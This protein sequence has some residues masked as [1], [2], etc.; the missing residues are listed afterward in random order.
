MNFFRQKNKFLIQKKK[1]IFLTLCLLVLVVPLFSA[2][3]QVVRDASG[4]VTFINGKTAI[5]YGPGPEGGEIIYETI[6][7]IGGTGNGVTQ[8]FTLDP[9]GNIVHISTGAFPDNTGNIV[10]TSGAGA[11]EDG[12]C[13]FS[14]PINCLAQG[15]YYVLFLINKILL[16]VGLLFDFVIL[17]TLVKMSEMIG[18]IDGIQAGWVAIR[19]LSNII[20]IFA[21]LYISIATILR[22]SGYQAKE[23][24]VKV[25]IVALLINF[26]LFFTKVIIDVANTFSTVFYNQITASNG[27]GGGAGLAD[28]F[29][30]PF[31]LATIASTEK[32]PDPLGGTTAN[33]D[34]AK[35]FASSPNAFTLFMVGSIFMLIAIFVFF[36]ATI[37]FLIR[38]VVL[39]ILMVLSPFAFAGSILPKTKTYADKWWTSLIAESFFAPLFMIMIWLSLKIID[40]NGFATLTGTDGQPGAAKTLA[41][42]II[43]PSSGK[44]ALVMK[45]AI[46]IVFLIASL[47]ISKQLT[48]QASGAALKAYEW[49][50]KKAQR[51]LGAA[52]FG[53]AGLGLRY[54][55]G[56]RSA[57]FL[58]TD[59]GK[60]LES[61]K[62]LVDK[63]RYD[64][65]AGL[66][67]S[68][69]DARALAG[70][71]SGMG[72]AAGTG[73][74]EKITERREKALIEASKRQARASSEELAKIAGAVKEEGD[75]KAEREAI[76]FEDKEKTKPLAVR[77]H[78]IDVKAGKDE[79]ALQAVE[80]R[81]TKHSEASLQAIL[82]KDPEAKS[83]ADEE[84]RKA[85]ADKSRL[86]RSLRNINSERDE[87]RGSI[88][89]LSDT[90]KANVEKFKQVSRVMDKAA[91][92][93]SRVKQDAKDAGDVRKHAYLSEKER[94][95]VY[96]LGVF[97]PKQEINKIRVDMSKSK[98]ERRIDDF[99]EVLDELEK[100]EKKTESGIEHLEE[101]IK[102]VADDVEESKK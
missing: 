13:G 82:N 74:Y 86:E 37:L 7:T 68:S 59:K 95:S 40:G 14:H 76:P 83:L 49:T 90:E 15:A 4:H 47:I 92:K 31:N 30:K 67:K 94:P 41:Q 33:S 88:D 78:E 27:T 54:S 85:A 9:S 99:K 69:F 53:A 89:K 26:S 84:L 71:Q 3:A 46:V 39:V 21:L 81:M 58:Q 29:M 100:G 48:G 45:F 77:S 61:S 51:G 34:Q 10:P 64:A 97:A 20:I 43:D 102:G 52:T 19:D 75:K 91:D 32:N 56:R 36:A 6:G 22:L 1:Y 2:H 60:A 24:L 73:G 11:A 16:L 57:Q 55:L 23:L 28:R 35:V 70:K 50:R 98:K 96:N 101:E 18:K 62:R 38:F 25:I 42:S 65:H 5:E 63:I 72:Q 8:F 93:I 44:P 17:N 12:T 87:L 80:A 79:K 66:A